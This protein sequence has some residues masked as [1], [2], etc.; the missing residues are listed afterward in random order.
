MLTLLCC[1]GVWAQLASDVLSGVFTINAN[2]V[3]VQFSKGNLQKIGS[4]YQ[5]AEHQYD[6]IGNNQNDSNKDLFAF[7]PTLTPQT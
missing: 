5:F 2:G 3:K 7:N 6:Y 1:T 4:N